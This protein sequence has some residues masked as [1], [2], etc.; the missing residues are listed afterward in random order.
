[1]VLPLYLSK[2]KVQLIYQSLLDLCLPHHCGHFTFQ[3]ADY[4]C[5]DFGS[6]STLHK[7][8]YSPVTSLPWNI[9]QVRQEII[10]LPFKE[11]SADWTYCTLIDGLVVERS[12]MK[13]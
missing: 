1:M 9:L 12:V 10:L 13:A 5:M 6:S 7:L 2:L 8:I 3:V 11:F 4:K